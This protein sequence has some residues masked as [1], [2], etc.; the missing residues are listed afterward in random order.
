MAIL[1]VDFITEDLEAVKKYFKDELTGELVK[2]DIGKHEETN[3]Y[4]AQFSF[5][6]IT[7]L[8][9]SIPYGQEKGYL[10][11]FMRMEMEKIISEFKIATNIRD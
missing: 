3:K 9:E 4:Q 2:I 1:A 10:S 6:V 5:D 8:D 11:L 7:S